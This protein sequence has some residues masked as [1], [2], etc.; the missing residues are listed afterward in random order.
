MDYEDD[1]LQGQI[2]RM[3][4]NHNGKTLRDLRDLI[5][6]CYV[7]DVGKVY[8]LI[9]KDLINAF[10]RTRKGDHVNAL[11][12]AIKRNNLELCNCL[13]GNG[14]DVNI[15]YELGQTPVILAA[16]CQ[17]LEV[18]CVLAEHG[19][20]IHAKDEMGRTALDLLHHDYRERSLIEAS[21]LYN[22]S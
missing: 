2:I 15:L 3:G 1:V 19:A 14:C 9:R 5:K 16:A 7:G 18:A 10:A 8:P 12:I 11:Y 22:K 17:H 4:L 20:D 6:A 13:I 21:L